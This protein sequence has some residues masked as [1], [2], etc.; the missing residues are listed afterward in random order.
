MAAFE[1]LCVEIQSQVDQWLPNCAETLRADIIRV[2][3]ISDYFKQQFGRDLVMMQSLIESQELE[4]SVTATYY[5]EQL[6]HLTIDDLDSGLRLCRQRA[7]ARIIFRDLTRRA[8]LEETTSDLSNLADACID[9]SLRVHY[10]KNCQKYG[11]PTGAETGAVQQ[12][13]VLA[14]GKL[15]AGELNLS[16]DIDLIFLYDEPGM[17]LSSTHEFSNQEFFVRTSRDVI[18]SLDA[19]LANGFVFRVDMRLRPYG[20]SGA[21]ILNRTAMEKYFYEQGRDWERYAFVKARAAAGNIEFG[22]QFLSWLR[23]F[24]YRKHLDFGAVDALREMKHLIDTQVASKEMLDDVK[25]GPGGIREVEFVVQALQ[26]I[27]GG[28]E[29]QLQERKILL[30]MDRLATGNYLPTEEVQ[31]LREAYYFLRNSEH[32]IQAEK[33]R[34]TQRLPSAQLSQERLAVAMGFTNYAD[35]LLALSHHRGQVIEIFSRFMSSNNAE[36]EFRKEGH[37]LWIK[38]WRDPDMEDALDI[39]TEHGYRR[40][41]EVV[42]LLHDLSKRVNVHDIHEIGIERLD[43]LMPILMSLAAREKDP[44]QTLARLLPI[45]EQIA[46]RSTYIV[47]L[48]ENL[49]A[50][51][52]M[53]NLC[54]MSSWVANHLAEMPILLYELSDRQT[55]EAVFD[56]QQLA[57]ELSQQLATADSGDL[58]VQMDLLRQFKTGAVLKVAVLEL[59]DLLPLMKASDALTAI[60][61]VALEQAVDL[62]WRAMLER[63]GE[64]CDSDRVPQGCRFAIIAYGKLGG[65]E[66]G[67]GSDLDLVM[68]ADVDQQGMTNGEKSIDNGVFF[69]RLAQR[70]IH[71]LTRYTR[72]GTV[73]EV[74]LR[75]R[76][77]GNK[78][79]LVSTFGAYERYL[80]DTAWTWEHQALVRSRFVAGHPELR[81]KFD[82]IRAAILQRPRDRAVLLNEVVSMREKM[83]RHLDVQATDSSAKQGAITPVTE[84]RDEVLVSGFDLKHGAGAIIDI[85]FMVQFWVLAIS[86]EHPEVARWSDKVRL[87][88]ALE[89]VGVFDSHDRKLL[90]EAYLAYRSAVHYQWLGG[91]MSSFKRLNQYRNGVVDIWQ[92]CMAL[93]KT[94]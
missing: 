23:P 48:L 58:E 60:A 9:A 84:S 83:R 88:E 10:A 86:H 94:S 37:L 39:L 12:M 22:R 54:G 73:Y 64:P 77:A 8:T 85:E 30:A 33:D 70:V 21:L 59:S 66:L 41:N 11:Y 67:Y 14:L 87:L 71:I 62:A 19:N 76:P 3:A 82:A 75:L 91:E 29:S 68:L 35:Y 1:A 46:R 69:H 92:R 89:L 47:Y 32:V 44:D 79:P 45:V 80:S 56:K 24:V 90:H 38:I 93:G 17:V 6:K 25:L 18:R 2:C 57:S 63:F 72:F 52:R 61:E 81:P 28:R 7:M 51:K 26:L 49:D 36:G 5:Q 78:G 74:D 13:V 20:E 53:V 27:W 50:L 42:R 31:Q 4:Q 34:Q 15:G 55:H 16:S 43:R 65:F 40:A